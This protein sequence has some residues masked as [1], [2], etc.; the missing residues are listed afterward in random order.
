MQLLYIVICYVSG[1]TWIWTCLE[2]RDQLGSKQSVDVTFP[3]WL[4]GSGFLSSVD[5]GG[6][7]GSF[8]AGYL[9]DYMVSKVTLNTKL[10][11]YFS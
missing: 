1:Y 4:P 7:V 9:S 5:I 11:F 3:L 6:F 10:I 8:L 2:L